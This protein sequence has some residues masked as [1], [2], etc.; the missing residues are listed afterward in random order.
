MNKN[1]LNEKNSKNE[2][3]IDNHNLSVETVQT[4]DEASSIQ[5]EKNNNSITR[6]FIRKIIY[7]DKILLF[8]SVFLGI[9]AWVYVTHKEYPDSE[10]IISGVQIDFKASIK[11]TEAEREGYRIYDS[12]ISKVDI[13]VR[14]NRTKLAFLDKN[15]FYATVSVDNYIGEQPVSLPIQIFKTQSNDVNCSYELYDTTYASVY[16]YKE[17]T[18]KIPIEVAAPNIKAA[19]GY[20]IKSITAEEITVTGPDHIVNSIN[21]CVLNV[22]YDTSYDERK[23]H[24][25]S[26]T[27]DKLIFYN[28]EDN[29]INTEMLPYFIDEKLKI[30]K[31]DIIVTV[32]VSKIKELS[33]TYNLN[34]VPSYFDPQFILDRMSLEPSKISVSSDDPSL[35]SIDTLPVAS[36]ENISLSEIDMDFTKTFSVTKA[37]ESY[38]KLVNDSKIQELVVTFNSDG[39]DTKTFD[40]LSNF[41]FKNPYSAKYATEAVTKCLTEVKVMGPAADIAKLKADDLILEVDVSK[42]ELSSAGQPYVGQ[43]TYTVTVMPQDQKK[44]KNIWVVGQYEADV[45]VTPLREEPEITLV[46][47][48]D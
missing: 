31:D 26:A 38:P 37:L 27:L 24:P 47:T 42:N 18:K 9:F 21:R 4:I 41:S 6:K 25:V 8:I 20:K 7:N 35:E 23:S 45:N 40:V 10:Q 48:T 22:D 16:I 17:I 11:G 13:N 1:S 19:T 14:A 43:S 3:D 5:N 46:T 39:L 32:Y 34:N 36:D 2:I 30:D 28:E 15:D 33:L 12:D 29:P 44:F